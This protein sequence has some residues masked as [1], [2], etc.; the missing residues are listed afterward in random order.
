MPNKIFLAINDIQINQKPI[1]IKINESYTCLWLFRISKRTID[2]VCVCTVYGQNIWIKMPLINQY[3]VREKLFKNLQPISVSSLIHSFHQRIISNIPQIN[4]R[5]Q[6]ILPISMILS[7]HITY[8][9]TCRT[10][11][12][13]TT[14]K[15]V[16]LSEKEEKLITK[17]SNRYIYI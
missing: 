8:I 7:I 1:M 3:S 12:M 13:N 17:K 9:H 11:Q 16:H 10:F 2:C 14:H 15:T 6:R 5:P 4:H